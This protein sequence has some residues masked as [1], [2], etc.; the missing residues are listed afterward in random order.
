MK[1]TILGVVVIT[2]LL[3]AMLGVTVNAATFTA[4]ENGE[5]VTVT[6]RTNEMVNSMEF[7][8]K[9]DSTKCQYVE[10]SISTGLKSIEVD[11]TTDN[12]FVS[13]M[14]GETTTLLLTFKVLEKGEE[15]PFTIAN[16]EFTK[17]GKIISETVA[18]PTVVVTVAK[19]AP[20]EPTPDDEKDKPVVT[21]PAENDN[22]EEENKQEETKKETET[23]KYVDE[24]GK[25][26][27]A[28]PQTGSYLPAIIVAV[29]TLGVV[30]MASY[31]IMKNK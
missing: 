17:E 7:D 28:I 11:A 16:T 14:T 13:A 18:N 9:Y 21:P 2:M 29:V 6:I 26:I 12:V 24:E 22:K 23:I 30:G 10:N 1:K 5:Y 25:E 31:K 27:K 20:V 15:L 3:V 4:S 8:L 19:P